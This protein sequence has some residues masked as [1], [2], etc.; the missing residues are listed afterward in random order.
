M[1]E[2][3]RQRVISRGQSAAAQPEDGARGDGV[4][5]PRGRGTTPR[6]WLV[7]VPDLR[8]ERTPS[9]S[10]SSSWGG[11]LRSG[12]F[13][14]RWQGNLCCPRND[15][16][17]VSGFVR[18]PAGYHGD[19]RRRAG[20]WSRF[21]PCWSDVYTRA[22]SHCHSGENVAP[23]STPWLSEDRSEQDCAKGFLLNSRCLVRLVWPGNKKG[24]RK[25]GLLLAC[26]FHAMLTGV[27]VGAGLRS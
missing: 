19:A 12:A 3:G 4:R 1:G 5:C 14:S 17:A 8:L 16:S 15:P 22:S 9:G 10:E 2:G 25:P 6:N 18:F 21:D 27:R 11:G 24:F 20:T 23:G 13:L 7:R 26:R